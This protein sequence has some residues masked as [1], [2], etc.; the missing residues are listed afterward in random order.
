M[1]REHV[2]IVGG[3][4]LGSF[5]AWS[6]RDQG[7]V[8]KITVI[9]KDASYQYCSTALSAAC[10]RLQFATPLNIHMSLFGVDFLRTVKAD[11]GPDTVLDCECCVLAAGAWSGALARTLDID[12]P[13]VAKKRTV[14]NF[15]APVDGSGLPMFFDT[16]GFWMLPKGHEFIGGIYPSPKDDTDAFGDFE[17]HHHLMENEFWPALVTRI[18]AMEELHLISSWAGHHENNTRDN[19]GIVGP[20]VPSACWPTGPRLSW[21]A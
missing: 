6:L 2:V 18:P 1:S 11:L 20:H 10:I 15:T 14:F 9:E 13:V 16:S 8:G 7:F 5:C 17:P 3:A 12:L 19:N 21:L 4:I